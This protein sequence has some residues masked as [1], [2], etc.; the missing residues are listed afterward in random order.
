[1]KQ[2]I[3][4]AVRE[5]TSFFYS[6][7]AYVVIGLFALCTTPI[8]FIFFQPGEEATMRD[9]L[10]WVVWL[11]VFIA[12]AISMRLLSEEIRSGTVELLMTSP[13]SDMQVVLG[14]WLGALG[15][16]CTLFVPLLIF[17]AM[18]MW[19]GKPDI[20]PIF[21]GLLGLLLVGGLYLAIGAFVSA[22][23]EN[24]IISFLGTAFIILTLTIIFF[25]LARTPRVPPAIQKA[26]I[27]LNIDNQ[28]KD[29][30]LGLIDV[31]NFVYFISLTAV[32]LFLAAKLLESRRWR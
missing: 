31:S 17:T 9:T 19:Y 14:K 15:F 3:T 18:L 32:F 8:F 1:M 2:T 27:Y 16:F 7:I 13:I 23:T 12:P 11:M 29:F 22:V 30:T 20:G 28:F 26:L 6:P 4:I 24:Q 25:F 10:S 21:T 5:L